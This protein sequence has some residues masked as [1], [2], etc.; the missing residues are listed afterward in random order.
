M[1]HNSKTNFLCL[2]ITFLLIRSSFSMIYTKTP[3]KNEAKSK[4]KFCIKK[5]LKKCSKQSILT[6]LG[7]NCFN[8]CYVECFPRKT[9]TSHVQKMF[10]ELKD[11]PRFFCTKGVDPTSLSYKEVLKLFATGPCVPV[12][13][14]PGVMATKLTIEIDCAV[15]SQKEEKV[16]SRCGWNACEKST[17][18]FWKSVPQ[19]EYR[20]WIPTLMSD[21]SILSISE[22]TNICFASLIKPHYDSSKPVESMFFPREGIKIKVHGFSPET[23]SDNKCG[24]SAIENLLPLPVQTA[25]TEGFYELNLVLQH[26]GY[27]PGL[28]MQAIPYNFYYSYRKNEF[29]MSFRDNLVR[30]N[31]LTGKQTTIV[32]HSMGNLNT[33]HNLSLMDLKQ[34]QLIFN[35][36]S[37][38]APFLGTVR[39]QKLLLT[40]SDEFAT[41]GGLIGFKFHPFIDTVN[42]QMS[43]YEM[44]AVDPFEIYKGEP[45]MKEIQKKMDYE[46][47]F[48]KI[49][50]ADSGFLFWPSASQTCYDRYLENI[51]ITCRMKLPDITHMPLLKIGKDEYFMKDTY[52]MFEEHQLNVYTKILYNKLKDPE[53]LKTF[54]EVPVILIFTNSIITPA[55][56]EFGDD[57]QKMIQSGMYPRPILTGHV[58]GDQTVPAYSTF[59]PALRWAYGFDNK[60]PDD[61]INHQPVKFVEFCSVVRRDESVYDEK[62][63]GKPFKMTKNGY[64]GLRCECNGRENGDDYS[65]CVHAKTHV[66]VYTIKFILSV[67]NAKYFASSE[68]IEYIDSLNE[69]TL[70]EEIKGCHTI[71]A[72]IFS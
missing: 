5:C 64:I 70:D 15:F 6:D 51:D 46:A 25:T 56:Y 52:R 14:V 20:L 53:L 67:L 60:K 39:S 48:P 63:P 32:A 57:F 11:Y 40:G 61:K 69:K 58:Y 44:A 17:Y 16:F 71:R 43:I 38:S 8:P 28:T 13:L 2:M 29:K 45:F 54:P 19:A 12:I 18:E 3:K 33:L 65:A 9:T 31:K 55:Y 42:N 26:V 34:K 72:S 66:D 35:W 47:F 1:N 22:R 50:F 62:I 68:Q 23:K 4:V 41:F 21:L 59:L 36:I 30:L 10:N 7:M 24:C 49:N 27:V 37:I